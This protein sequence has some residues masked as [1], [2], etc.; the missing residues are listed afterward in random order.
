MKAPK[1]T[2]TTKFNTCEL[3]VA[4][5]VKESDTKTEKVI[6]EY[7]I[8]GKKVADDYFPA[9]LK[10]TKSLC[11]LKD[12]TEDI[13]REF[14]AQGTLTQVFAEKDDEGKTV[15]RIC[16]IDTWLG[17]VNKVT[18]TTTS[19]DDHKKGE[20]LVRI[21]PYAISMD[22]D[23]LDVK[24]NNPNYCNSYDGGKCGWFEYAGDTDNNLS[25]IHI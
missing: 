20:D 3:L 5:G 4:L 25:L 1:A 22:V 18:K 19:R 11:D 7:Y 17:K 9:T 14:G 12:K 15:Y 16:S 10:H 8:N 21:I 6:A 24:H 23:S 13:Y 2:F